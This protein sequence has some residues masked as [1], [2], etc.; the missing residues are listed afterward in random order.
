MA[1][2]GDDALGDEISNDEDFID[3][4]A[5]AEEVRNLDP[6]VASKRGRGRPRKHY[7]VG[8]RRNS[9]Q[10]TVRL[11]HVISYM[12]RIGFRSIQ[13]FLLTL[14]SDQ[15][16]SHVNRCGR[17]FSQ[18]G[19][20]NV[21]TMWMEDARVYK[22]N[23]KR[24]LLL[25][26]A[27]D[28]LR[29]S[30]RRLVKS[31]DLRRQ[32]GDMA[33]EVLQKFSFQELNN[34]YQL[35]CPELWR[36]IRGLTEPARNSV[37]TEDPGLATVGETVGE[38]GDVNLRGD[39]EPPAKRR[40]IGTPTKNRDLMICSCI[41][42]VLYGCSWRCNRFQ[43][44][45]GYW[46]HVENAHKNSIEVLHALGLTTSYP[47]IRR[48]EIV[49]SEKSMS[50]ALT[51][52]KEEPFILTWDNINRKIRV[53]EEVLHS[54]EYMISWT[55][56]G[57]IFMK[58]DGIESGDDVPQILQLRLP[59][60][61]LPRAPTIPAA[62]VNEKPRL[63]LTGKDFMLSEGAKMYHA[64]V[65]QQSIGKIL[66]ANFRNQAGRK[67]VVDRVEG[68]VVVQKKVKWR[69][70][71]IPRI[72]QVPVRRIDAQV[73]PT[74]EADEATI[75]GTIE[76]MNEYIR[77]KLGLGDLGDGK[78]ICSGDQLSVKLLRTARFLTNEEGVGSSLN[79]A[80]TVMGLFH[81]RMAILRMI[82]K[83]FSGAEDGRE[84]CSLNRFRNLL[85]RTQITSKVLN[86]KACEDLVLQVY[87]GCVIAMA[88]EQMEKSS[89]T[90]LGVSFQGCD[91]E[92]VIDDIRERWCAMGFVTKIREEYGYTHPH[93]KNM[94][95]QLSP[96]QEEIMRGDSDIVFENATLYVQTV[97]M[98]QD[99]CDAIQ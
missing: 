12:K 76:I 94:N 61:A 80:V 20:D 21:L 60:V 45:M 79:W 67:R 11:D 84:P 91:M 87:E 10:T 16:Q 39:N 2:L 43:S 44:I 56:G 19:L 72:F 81:L 6:R 85:R 62:W 26:L 32:D 48:T 13:D 89:L 17:F 4:E 33:P 8:R 37:V 9:A 71:I 31:G 73:L 24:D 3:I 59:D 69:P 34:I 50:A 93:R 77:A 28:W 49:I 57:I 42:I 96:E 40:K 14:F 54:K 78:I 36:F 70:D 30:V 22:D 58:T 29:Q 46:L 55:V 52:V 95:T 90:A 88:M 64:L 74:L 63:T 1:S 25:R 66:Y 75:E 65:F 41:S 86:F 68:G 35:K 38:N 53:R 92:R 18:G 97:G 7:L 15:K 27:A 23:T 98:Y 47:H 99:L 83:F 5:L 51:R 82:Y